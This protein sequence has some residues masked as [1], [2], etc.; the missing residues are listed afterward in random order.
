MPGLGGNPGKMYCCS[1][2]S[3]EL[4]DLI[5]VTNERIALETRFKDVVGFLNTE[6]GYQG[7]FAENNLSCTSIQCAG[8]FLKERAPNIMGQ[9]S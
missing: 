8:Y 3:R 9:S 4:K 7:S 2:L 1:R 5:G 6:M